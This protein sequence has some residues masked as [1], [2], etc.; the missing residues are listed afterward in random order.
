MSHLLLA[1]AVSFAVGFYLRGYIDTL[2]TR[3][4]GVED[5]SACQKCD[6]ILP[7]FECKNCGRIA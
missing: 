7:G 4:R 6:A 5:E 1:M 2:E 3:D